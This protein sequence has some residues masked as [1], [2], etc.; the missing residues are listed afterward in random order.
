MSGILSV[1]LAFVGGDVGAVLLRWLAGRFGG[2]VLDRVGDVIDRR[3][4]KAEGGE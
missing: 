4:K 1:L 3:K 2:K